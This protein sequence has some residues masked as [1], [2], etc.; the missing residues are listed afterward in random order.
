MY[1]IVRP[2]STKSNFL[3]KTSKKLK[4]R[5]FGGAS[6]CDKLSSRASRETATS[7]FNRHRYFGSRSPFA[8]LVL[9][10]IVAIYH[11]S[12]PPSTLVALTTCLLL[13]TSIKYEEYLLYA[14]YLLA[15]NVAL[16]YFVYLLFSWWRR[17]PCSM[18]ELYIIRRLPRRV[19]E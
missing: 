6:W 3:P 11:I 5:H 16:V 15:Q 1:I 14:I 10:V 13:L 12:L 8:R 19:L 17:I 2:T 9:V 4:I 7:I 18:R